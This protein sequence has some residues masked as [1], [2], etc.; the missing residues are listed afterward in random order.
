M[1]PGTAFIYL[2]FCLVAFLFARSQI[3][4]L[5]GLFPEFRCLAPCPGI[6]AL[7]GKLV[8][9]LAPVQLPETVH[10]GVQVTDLSHPAER[11]AVPSGVENLPL[12]QE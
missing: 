4:N 1:V 7:T 3:N 11:Q 8:A 12:S 5:A 9:H 2:T 6:P 10:Q